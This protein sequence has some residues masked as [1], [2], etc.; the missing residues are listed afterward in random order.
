MASELAPV[1]SGNDLLFLFSKREHGIGLPLG[2][3]EKLI[4]VAAKMGI[5]NSVSIVELR[6]LLLILNVFENFTPGEPLKHTVK[7][8]KLPTCR[9]SYVITGY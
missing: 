4:P 6:V 1:G 5:G 9:V 2:I 8:H 7:R 3:R